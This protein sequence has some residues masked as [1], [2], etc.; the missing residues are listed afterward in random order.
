MTWVKICGMTN[1]EDTL[2]AVDA[3]ADAVGFVFYGKS[4]RCVTVETA[5][6]IAQKLPESVE[7]VGVFV[8]EPPDRISTITKAAAL[9]SAQIYPDFQNPHSIPNDEFLENVPCTVIVALSANQLWNGNSDQPDIITG[10]RVSPTAKERISGVLLDSGSS[11]RPGGTGR[12]FRWT[13]VGPMV[14]II[15]QVGLN[16]LV[17]GGLTPKNVGE[18]I[19]VLHPS[20]VDVTSGVEASPGKKDPDKVR[21]FVGAVRKLDRRV[22]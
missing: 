21:A 3:G 19:E 15:R 7:K 14:E 16:L 18:A 1:L 8:G 17:A 11:E 22:G 2:V 10:F 6:E 4:P 9:T 12:T 13:E 20:G 5:R